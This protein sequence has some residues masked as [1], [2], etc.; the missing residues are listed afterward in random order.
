MLGGVT[1]E[2]L[3]DVCRNFILHGNSLIFNLRCSGD[4]SPSGGFSFTQLS[5]ATRLCDATS[6]VTQLQD[7]CFAQRDLCGRLC[8]GFQRNPTSNPGATSTV[9]FG[10]SAHPLAARLAASLL[11]H[12]LLPLETY[13]L[14]PNRLQMLR[15]P[16]TLGAGRISKSSPVRHIS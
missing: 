7:F 8:E 2:D 10:S 12:L 16:S 14:A 1:I 6:A 11:L 4:N 9:F 5:A 3:M 13:Y 15:L